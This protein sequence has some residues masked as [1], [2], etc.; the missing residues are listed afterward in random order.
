MTVPPETVARQVCP[1][2]DCGHPTENHKVTRRRGGT[3][4]RCTVPGCVCWFRK[5][6]TMDRKEDQA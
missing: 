4:V 2:E 3:W 1:H 5:R 6:K